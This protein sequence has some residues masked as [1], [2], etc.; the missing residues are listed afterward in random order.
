MCTADR[1][2]H[3]VPECDEIVG[4]LCPASAAYV[5]AEAEVLIRR[6]KY[7]GKRDIVAG[8]ASAG[9]AL[10]DPGA[11][12]VDA[13]VVH[14]S[15]GAC[16]LFEKDTVPAVVVANVVVGN[17]FRRASIKIQAVS[18][19]AF[20]ATSSWSSDCNT[21]PS[22]QLAAQVRRVYRTWLWWK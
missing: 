19:I 7:I 5:Q 10:R 11:M 20:I 13:G 15:V 4:T 9:G 2:R 8:G 6:V 12:I 3:L 14:N 17:T 22:S 16:T 18:L 21:A 1:A